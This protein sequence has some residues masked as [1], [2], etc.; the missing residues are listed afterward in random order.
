M[1]RQYQIF[2]P[3]PVRAKFG[4]HVPSPTLNDLGLSQEAVAINFTLHHQPVRIDNFGPTIPVDNLWMLEDAQIIMNLVHWDERTVD[5]CMME[6]AA[7]GIE[8]TRDPSLGLLPGFMAPAG[9]PLGG[10]VPAFFS[11]YHYVGL[12]IVPGNNKISPWAFPAAFLTQNPIVL[13]LGTK[14]SILQLRWQAIPYQPII[15]YSTTSISGGNITIIAPGEI[16]SS[17][18]ALYYNSVLTP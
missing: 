4:A 10:G 18:A 2:G 17:G 8:P 11:G 7:G 15:S 9:L 1:T 3:A 14:R 16:S 12:N 5:R 13:P 6:S